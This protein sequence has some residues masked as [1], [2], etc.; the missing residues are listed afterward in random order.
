[1]QITRI[2]PAHRADRCWT[3]P[4]PSTFTKA[5]DHAPCGVRVPVQPFC[6]AVAFVSSDSL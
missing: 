3:S 4:T 2:W 1:M 6:V 5:Y